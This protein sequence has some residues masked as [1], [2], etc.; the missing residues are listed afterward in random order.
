MVS[1]ET[2]HNTHMIIRL[3]RSLAD[4]V[5]RSLADHGSQDDYDNYLGEHFGVSFKH[6]PPTFEDVGADYRVI[7]HRKFQVAVIRHGLNII[8]HHRS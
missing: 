2:Q 3:S 5:P 8:K 6:V 7:D 4:H 1:K